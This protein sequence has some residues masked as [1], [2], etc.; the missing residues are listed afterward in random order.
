[1]DV[2]DLFSPSR[3]QGRYLTSDPSGVEQQHGV[4]RGSRLDVG[5]RV[6]DPAATGLSVEFFASKLQRLPVVPDVMVV[7]HPCA[8]RNP[9]SPVNVCQLRGERRLA[10]GNGSR[11]NNYKTHMLL[12]PPAPDLSGL[13]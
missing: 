4:R 7:L 9:N 5:D 6:C 12:P 13:N 11:K 2:E 3:L 1:M 8:C 10:Y